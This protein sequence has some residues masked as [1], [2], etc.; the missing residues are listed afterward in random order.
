MPYFPIFLDLSGRRVLIVGGGGVAL[1]KAEKLLPYGPALTVVAPSL[2]PGFEALPQA[3][4]LRR[5]FSP[6]DLRGCALVLAATDQP[7][8]NREISALC[9]R[10]GIPVNVADDRDACSFLFPALVRRGAVSVGISTGGASPAA[11]AWLRGEIEAL[12][13]PALE[14]I[15]P[16]LEAQRAPLKARLPREEQRSAVLKRLFSACLAA[17]GPLSPQALEDAIREEAGTS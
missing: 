13:P 9:A 12:L 14:D 1:R 6:E 16:W 5:P 11:A 3:T 8:L 10:A 4:L 2:L 17:G 7:A 15:L